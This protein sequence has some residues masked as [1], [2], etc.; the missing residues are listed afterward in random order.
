MV[1]TYPKGRTFYA[2]FGN[3]RVEYNYYVEL[4]SRNSSQV[5]KA[6]CSE[7]FKTDMWRYRYAE[8]T[9]NFVYLKDATWFVL[10]WG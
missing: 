1:L 7:N 8:N 6:W 5:Q 3:K 4:E 9:F 2:D 10:R